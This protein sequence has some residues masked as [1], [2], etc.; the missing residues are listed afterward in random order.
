M[1]DKLENVQVRR[2]KDKV[3]KMAKE[4]LL[5]Q[6]HENHWADFI[7]FFSLSLVLLSSFARFLLLLPEGL[8]FMMMMMMV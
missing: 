1:R 6:E 2:V 7:S 5:E 8:K 4:E 3:E